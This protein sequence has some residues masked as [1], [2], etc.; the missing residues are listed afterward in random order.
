MAYEPAALAPYLLGDGV[1]F[2]NDAEHNRWELK[3]EKKK[4][5]WEHRLWLL[6]Q[7]IISAVPIAASLHRLSFLFSNCGFVELSK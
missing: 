5:R 2:H 3:K 4:N 1:D 7:G 6:V